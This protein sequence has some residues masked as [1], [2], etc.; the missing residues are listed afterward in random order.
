[1]C[2]VCFSPSKAKTSL[3]LYN[4]LGIT[5]FV[6]VYVDDI[7]AT[8][9]SDHAISALLRDLNENFAI[10]DLGDLH[11]FLGIKVN[12]MHILTQKSML[13]S[14]LTKL[15]CVVA[16]LLACTPLS[17]SEQLSLTDGTPLC[18]EDSTQ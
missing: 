18:L 14:Y 11:F 15:S 8:S 13:Q 9:F 10:K 17:F 12:K 2:G 4:N 6:L 1:L 5:I 3:L 16:S 7:I